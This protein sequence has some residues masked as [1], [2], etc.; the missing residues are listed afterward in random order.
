M[1]NLAQVLN[2]HPRRSESLREWMCL[3]GAT[4]LLVSLVGIV[5][6]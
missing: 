5:M 1:N 6:A 2:E 4:T 3:I